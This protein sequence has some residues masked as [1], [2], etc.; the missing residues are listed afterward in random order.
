MRERQPGKKQARTF[1][2]GLIVIMSIIAGLQT[3]W[4]RLEVG[5][6]LFAACAVILVA[7]IFAPTILVPLY[8]L[9]LL[10][11]KAIGVVM[12]PVVLGLVFY[13]V[14]AP[15][16]MVL[17]LARKD[18]LD[19]KFNIDSDSYWKARET[20]QDGLHRYERQY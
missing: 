10:V 19:K 1:S 6:G 15:V 8:K 7:L 3:Y 11:S 14:F 9:M 17:R 4:G 18:I 12:T 20:T 16:A 13:L 5:I 2:I